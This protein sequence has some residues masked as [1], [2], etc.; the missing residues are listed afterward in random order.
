MSAVA[1]LQARLNASRLP[2]KVLLP[3]GAF[4]LID[5]AIQRLATVVP[6]IPCIPDSATD[7]P[8]SEYL[9]GDCVR[10]PEADVLRRLALAA[11]SCDGV[12]WVLRATAD[13]PF[14]LP[15]FIQPAL[16]AAA[17]ADADYCSIEG[18]PLGS[19][20]EMVRREALVRLD[21]LVVASDEREHA[22]LGLL[23]RPE[24]F[25]ITRWQVPVEYHL[26]DLRLT[27]D[28]PDDYRWVA[29][30]LPEEL[31]VPATFAWTALRESASRQPRTQHPE[32]HLASTIQSLKESAWTALPDLSP[33]PVSP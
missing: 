13:N 28:T 1:L 6:V 8:L 30:L 3:L 25:R 33:S 23:R 5:W 2:G 29:S 15:E 32:Q 27:V 24:R 17:A 26:P 16:A 10:G 12:E 9:A 22:T 21:Q 14:V 31:T 4:R 20:V 11:E 7:D 19:T 18:A